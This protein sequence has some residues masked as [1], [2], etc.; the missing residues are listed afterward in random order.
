M[1]HAA[2]LFG[3]YFCLKMEAT[4]SSETLAEF[5]LTMWRYTPKTELFLTTDMTISNPAYFL[6]L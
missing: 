2:S 1:T 4:Y 6:I 5:Q 3:L